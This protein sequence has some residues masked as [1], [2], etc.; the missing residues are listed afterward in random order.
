MKSIPLVGYSDKL[1]VRPNE[2]ISFKISSNLKK[3]FTASFV[4]IFVLKYILFLKQKIK[5]NIF[6]ISILFLIFNF[7]YLL[8]YGPI[9]RY[10]IGVC[11]VSISLI[12]F[13]AGKSRYEINDYFKYFLIL[14][15]LMYFSP[16]FVKIQ[17]ILMSYDVNN[18][19][20]SKHLVAAIDPVIINKIFFIK[21]YSQCVLK[22]F[23]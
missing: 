10:T 20:I 1:S 21:F 13:F 22:Q 7:T 23:H 18:L 16:S 19:N 12:G 5:L 17:L 11:L 6:L 2:T 14:P 9:P 8:F 3:N 4:F 15:I